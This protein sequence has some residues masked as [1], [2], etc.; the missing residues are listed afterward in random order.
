MLARSAAVD[1]CHGR[2]PRIAEH[3][4]FCFVV[5]SVGLVAI[6]DVEDRGAIENGAKQTSLFDEI[7]GAVKSV[8]ELAHTLDSIGRSDLPLLDPVKRPRC[9]F[10]A[11]RVDD[12]EQDLPVDFDVVSNTVGRRP[13]PGRDLD[14]VVFDEARDD[15]GLALVDS[16][17]DRKPRNFGARFAHSVSSAIYGSANSAKYPAQT[18]R[19]ASSPPAVSNT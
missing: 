17:H 14:R 7:L 9:V 8:D 13:R 16:T 5:L 11:G 1:E 3:L 19:C 18:S 12:R 4:H 15:A 10:E 2:L 6:N